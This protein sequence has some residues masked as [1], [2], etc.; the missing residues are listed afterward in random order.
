M[1][2]KITTTEGFYIEDMDY[3]K[4]FFE[5]NLKEFNF[6]IDIE[7]QCFYVILNHFLNI[8]IDDLIT[9]EGLVGFQRVS[10]KCLHI[11]ESIIEYTVE[12][13]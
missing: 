9:I 2:T 4:S 6:K 1:R 11:S 5:R 3:T 12:D 7:N 13:A 8:N 10:W